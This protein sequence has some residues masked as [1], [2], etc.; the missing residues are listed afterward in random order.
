MKDWPGPDGPVFEDPKGGRTPGASGQPESAGR[1]C[2]RW[3]R[4]VHLAGSGDVPAGALRRLQRHLARCER[5]RG[6]SGDLRRLRDR[7]REIRDL[8]A[9]VSPRG[10]LWPWIHAA[11]ASLPSLH[12]PG[13]DRA[14]ESAEGR[15]GAGAGARPWRPLQV[16]ALLAVSAGLVLWMA[17]PAGR[18]EESDRGL[19]AAL[20]ARW[21]AQWNDFLSGAGPRGGVPLDPFSREIPNPDVIDF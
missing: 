7:C 6:A 20:E 14:A 9:R 18:E 4:L 12:V 13:S 15:R 17:L 2:R 5:C 1:A 19:R 16:A 11:I 10:S 3:E 8:Q 21:A